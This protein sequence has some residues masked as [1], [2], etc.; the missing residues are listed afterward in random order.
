MRGRAQ[1]GEL[2]AEPLTETQAVFHHEKHE[3]HEPRAAWR[4]TVYVRVFRVFRGSKEAAR[5]VFDR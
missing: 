4:A 5:A 1:V 3:E 2:P